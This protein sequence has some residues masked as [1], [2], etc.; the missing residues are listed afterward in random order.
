MVGDL[1][2]WLCWGFATWAIAYIIAK[3]VYQG[4]A[5]PCEDVQVELIFK[6]S[7]IIENLAWAI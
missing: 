3:R 2:E 4:E 5:Q 6:L 1:G 7:W